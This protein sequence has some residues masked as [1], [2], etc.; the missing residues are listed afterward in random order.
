LIRFFAARLCNDPEDLASETISR[1]CRAI[2]AGV[3]LTSQFETFLFGVAKYIALEDYKRRQKTDLPLDELPP[4]HEPC[5]DPPDNTLELP[6]WKQ[7]LYHE[8]LEQCLQ[9][10]D[11]EQRDQLILFY[12]GN[13]E[14]EMKSNRK[15]LAAQL[16]TN[17][18][19]LSSRML[20]LRGKLDTC[21]KACVERHQAK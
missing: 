10:L 14:G 8:C 13:Q 17:I 4:G 20:R 6:K 12:Q 18:R 5:I 16:G 2:S 1:A 15:Q 7:D 11:K 3:E 21:I 9:K 19:A